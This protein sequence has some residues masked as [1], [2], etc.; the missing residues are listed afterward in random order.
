MAVIST[1]ASDNRTEVAKSSM[2]VNRLKI[3]QDTAT[4]YLLGRG[5]DF[6]IL[7]NI[8]A[9][10]DNFSNNQRKQVLQWIGTRQKLPVIDSTNKAQKPL[11]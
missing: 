2:H 8:I 6:Q 4:Y 1:F 7:A 5:E 10:P 9:D 11:K 3:V